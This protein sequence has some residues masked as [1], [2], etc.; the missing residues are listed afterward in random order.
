VGQKRHLIRSLQLE[1]LLILPS[2]HSYGGNM[3]GIS[4]E[5]ERARLKHMVK[6]LTDLRKLELNL[7]VHLYNCE[8]YGEAAWNGD[9]TTLV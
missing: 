5:Q 8:K 4:R 9:N 2:D 7:M 6:R 3:V 1:V